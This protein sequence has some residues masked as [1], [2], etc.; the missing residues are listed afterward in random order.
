MCVLFKK[1]RESWANILFKCPLISNISNSYYIYF[2]AVHFEVL[3]E[4]KSSPRAFMTWQNKDQ[5]RAVNQVK[6]WAYWIL[7]Q[8]RCLFFVDN[9]SWNLLM[10]FSVI[11]FS[12]LILVSHPMITNHVKDTLFCITGAKNRRKL[13]F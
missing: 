5:W 8:L 10:L 11:S 3:G 13:I 2:G 12:W 6:L 9:G 1:T 4:K 7:L